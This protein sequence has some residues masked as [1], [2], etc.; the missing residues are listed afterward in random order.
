MGQQEILDFLKE[1][2]GEWLF[3]RDIKKKLNTTSNSIYKNLK[4]LRK[5]NIIDF[6]AVGKRKIFKYKYK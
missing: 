2:S 6:K 5:S 3:T 1:K 4:S